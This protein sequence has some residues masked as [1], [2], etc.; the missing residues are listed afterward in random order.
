MY[1]ITL[2]VINDYFSF[3][4]TKYGVLGTVEV[5][6][7]KHCPRK[8]QDIAIQTIA[9]NSKALVKAQMSLP[10]TLID[11]TICEAKKIR[12]EIVKRRGRGVCHICST[13]KRQ[14]NC[15]ACKRIENLQKSREEMQG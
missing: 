15:K 9:S 4:P 11:R 12:K 1:A 7:G 5:K 3:I 13:T 8:L 6:R 2:D 10:N 14:E